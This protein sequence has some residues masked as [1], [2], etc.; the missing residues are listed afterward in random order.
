MSFITYALCATILYCVKILMTAGPTDKLKQSIAFE[1]KEKVLILLINDAQ[2][3]FANLTDYYTILGVK[4]TSTSAE[5]KNAFETILKIYNFDT[6]TYLLGNSNISSTHV[7]MFIKVIHDAYDTLGNVSNKYFYDNKDIIQTTNNPDD[8]IDYF[9]D[10]FVDDF[11][12][13]DKA[14][15][16]NKSELN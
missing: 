6:F 13:N 4:K 3:R 1:K 8:M 5:I 16:W 10:G 14:S 15:Y 12:Q 9:I 2:T 11:D 7:N